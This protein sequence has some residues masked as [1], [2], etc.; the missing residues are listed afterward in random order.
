MWTNPTA[1]QEV[2]SGCLRKSRQQEDEDFREFFEDVFE[3]LAKFGEIED[4]IVCENVGE[5][6]VG[7]V[8]V[9]YY[10][11]EDAKN[12]V[13]GMKDRYYAGKLLSTEFSPVS[14]FADACC[15]QFKSRKCPRGLTCNFAHLRLLP[16]HE[17]F[18][19]KVLKNQPFAGTRSKE[20]MERN[21][22]RKRSRH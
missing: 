22:S 12:C 6:M 17:N 21:G 11:E 19:S 7:H 5:H 13:E 20:L 8:F 2:N 10:D 16:E 18:L 3:E 14:E 1:E 9:K 15:R 4:F